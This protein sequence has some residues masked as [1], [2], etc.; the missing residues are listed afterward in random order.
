LADIYTEYNY[1]GSVMTTKYLYEYVN[2]DG[3]VVKVF[4]LP[5]CLLSQKLDHLTAGNN[6]GVTTQVLVGEGSEIVN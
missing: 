2:G 6:L 4:P 1:R 5:K 3:V